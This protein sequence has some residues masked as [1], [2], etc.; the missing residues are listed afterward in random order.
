[1]FALVGMGIVATAIISGYIMEHGNLSVLFQPA[2][3]VIIFGAAIGGFLIATPMKT[4]KFVISSVIRM[5]T[6]SSFAKQ[7]YMDVLML[8]N[9]VFYK[10]RQQ[11]LVSVE[12]DVDEP[13]Q[14][15]SFRIIPR[16]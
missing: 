2:E 3:F 13:D 7:D 8:L 1:M 5:F 16:Y 6:H 9:G 11:G 15:R 14:S 10:I 4:V 12:T